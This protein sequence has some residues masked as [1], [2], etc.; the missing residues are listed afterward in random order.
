MFCIQFR[1]LST[2]ILLL[3]FGLEIQA[4]PLCGDL[5]SSGQNELKNLAAQYNVVFDPNKPY[6]YRFP[7]PKYVQ[8]MSASGL[9]FEIRMKDVP[10]DSLKPID[11]SPV[12]SSRFPYPEFLGE[13]WSVD[14]QNFRFFNAGSRLLLKDASPEALEKKILQA[15]KENPDHPIK[16]TFGRKWGTARRILNERQVWASTKAVNNYLTRKPYLAKEDLFDLRFHDETTKD[17]NDFLILM[18]DIGKT[19]LEISSQEFNDGLL[20]VVRIAR[21]SSYD[22]WLQDVILGTGISFYP[23]PHFNRVPE[24]LK[25]TLEKFFD[26]LSS[27]GKLR[28]AEISRFNRFA[29]FSQPAMNAFM[30]KILEAALT[31]EYPIDLFIIEVDKFTSRLFGRLGFKKL[32]QISDSPEYLMYL[33]TRSPEF[34]KLYSEL[35]KASQNVVRAQEEK[36]SSMISWSRDWDMPEEFFDFSGPHRRQK[37]DQVLA[38]IVNEVKEKKLSLPIADKVLFSN[39]MGHFIRHLTGHLR[40]KD[41]VTIFGDEAFSVAEIMRRINPESKIVVSRSE[42]LQD[43]I[44]VINAFSKTSYLDQKSQLMKE[45]FSQL[46]SGGRAVFVE[47]DLKE[48][49]D[50]AKQAGFKT[51]SFYSSNK[52]LPFG[53]S[54]ALEKY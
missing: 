21:I 33:D 27:E 11:I 8:G 4:A 12:F 43:V 15:M 51:D 26:Q 39:E 28:I 44:V 14:G 13:R 54:V 50:L 25:K 47:K 49:M 7:F 18:K 36:S 30:K 10:R 42:T 22:H 3:L 19:P 41:S 29:D 16:G 32:I 23:L 17:N 34:K 53:A 1:Q 40:S 2:F 45:V 37:A 52:P 20:A 24:K 9:D 46:K 48:I 38:S 31:P 6:Y 35:E 5:L